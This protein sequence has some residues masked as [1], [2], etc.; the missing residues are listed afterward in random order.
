MENFMNLK[1][2]KYLQLPIKW[3]EE[4]RSLFNVNGT[5]NKS[6]ALQFY[7]ELQVQTET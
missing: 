2:T 6:R 1:Y 5:T 4:P 7:M 3:L